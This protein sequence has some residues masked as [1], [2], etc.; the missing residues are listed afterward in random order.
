MSLIPK[1]GVWVMITKTVPIE[2]PI[3]PMSFWYAIPSGKTFFRGEDSGPE[4]LYEDESL[5]RAIHVLGLYGHRDKFEEFKKMLYACLRLPNASDLYGEK[6]M[7]ELQRMIDLKLFSEDDLTQQVKLITPF[8][9]CCIQPHEY[10]VVKDM[11]PYV[12][13]TKDGHAFMRFLSKSKT[14]SGKIADQVFYLRS[15]GISYAEALGMAIG[16]VQSQNL[17]Y[18]EMHPEYQKA[19]TRY[20]DTYWEKKMKYCIEQKRTD[21]LDY[22][23]SHDYSKLPTAIQESYVD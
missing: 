4:Y 7:E 6:N 22:G 9:S 21:L 18:I 8:G 11:T 14:L 15:R 19:Y 20:W 17:F 5:A 1:S 13:A 16:N 10:N 3:D 2:Y 12:D 23:P